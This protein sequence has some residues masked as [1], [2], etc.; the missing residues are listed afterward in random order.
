M[1]Q[2]TSNRQ[3]ESNPLCYTIQYET[4][5]PYIVAAQSGGKDGNSHVTGF[6]LRNRK[7]AIV[8]RDSRHVKTVYTNRRL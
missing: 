3:L 4:T 7:I 6:L 5:A 1:F 8:L 2:E